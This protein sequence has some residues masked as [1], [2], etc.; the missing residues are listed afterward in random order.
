M[1]PQGAYPQLF[2][3]WR[4]LDPEDF[5]LGGAVFLLP[6]I[7]GGVTLYGYRT[8]AFLLVAGFLLMGLRSGNALAPLRGR[9]WLLPAGLLGVW[10][11]FQLVPLPPALIATLSPTADGIYEQ[12]FPGYRAGETPD[13]VA[14]LEAR[15]LERVPEAAA[16]QAPPRRDE[17]LFVEAGPGGRWSGWRPLTLM[18]AATQ[19][20]LFWY[21]ALLIGFVAIAH[22]VREKDTWDQYRAILFGLFLLLAVFGLVHSATA[23]PGTLFWVFKPWF[24]AE[25]HPFGPYVNPNNF[26]A[27]MEMAV[28]WIVGYALLRARR[29]RWQVLSDLKT[30]FFLAVALVCITAGMAAGS[31]FSTPVMLLNTMILVLISV[32]RRARL[33]VA[34]GAA[35]LS[36]VAGVI[37]WTTFVGERW[38]KV[39]SATGG[40]LEQIDRIRGV[41][42]AIPMAQDFWLTGCGFGAFR[43]VFSSYIPLGEKERW[44]ELHNDY[45]QVLVEGGSVAAILLVWLTVAFWYQVFGKGTFRTRRGFDSE[46]V[47][48]LLAMLTLSVHALFD[49]NHQIPGNALLFVTLGAMLMVRTAR[50]RERGE[51]PA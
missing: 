11:A 40:S 1:R 47:G 35:L 37:A 48:L 25:A 28:P 7:F 15:A 44:E 22:R 9:R 24:L 41:K 31:K 5:L 6:W 20:A 23:G 29:R 30:P 45:L 50:L 16:E 42:A 49:F 27:V 36:V 3:R 10:A 34:G 17:Q 46:A 18:P 14:A 19:E 2:V 51:E 12:V 13:V 26:A 38:R 8:A 21:V 4:L 43:D 39:L 33:P 32:P